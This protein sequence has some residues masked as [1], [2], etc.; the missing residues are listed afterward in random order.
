MTFARTISGGVWENGSWELGTGC[1]S[2]LPRPDADGIYGCQFVPMLAKGLHKAI[3]VGLR[4]PWGPHILGHWNTRV[5]N[6]NFAP[7]YKLFKKGFT[8]TS[9]RCHVVRPFEFIGLLLLWYLFFA[10]YALLHFDGLAA[11]YVHF[12][13]VFTRQIFGIRYEFEWKMSKGV[14]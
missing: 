8:C 6:I 7:R 2:L 13:I 14:G 4:V 3:D 10:F 12:W 1:W 11:R 5:N 9:P